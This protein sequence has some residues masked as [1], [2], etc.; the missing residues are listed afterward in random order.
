[1]SKDGE[2]AAA[3]FPFESRF[4]K[5]EGFDIHYVETGSGKPVLFVH[6]N[7]TSSYV[8]RNVVPKVSAGTGRRAI[9][10]DLLG[11]G[12]SEKPPRVEYTLKLHAQILQGFIEKLKL[13]NLVLMGEDWGGPLAAHYAIYHP[14]E[15]EGLAL[16]ETFLWPMSYE[17]DFEPKFR[18]PFKLMRSP[19]GYLFTQ[20]FNIMTRKLIPENCPISPE[21]LDYYIKSTPTIHSR[22]AIGAF[23]KLLPVQGKPKASFDFFMEIQEGLST[24]GFPVLWV[25]AS[26]GVVP[27]DD[28]PPSLRKFEAVKRQIPHM[29]VKSFGPG[30]HFLAEENPNRVSDLLIEWVQSLR[31]GIGT[32]AGLQPTRAIR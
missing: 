11:F 25:K 1:M 22:K 12:K 24:I 13:E 18:F 28:Y 27:S 26:P 8:W 5:V 9:A 4:T 7:P 30:H 29:V 3:Q 10:L 23:P 15:I 31:L 19:L 32:G 6:G 14:R 20:V 16:Q 21:S 2:S 17:D